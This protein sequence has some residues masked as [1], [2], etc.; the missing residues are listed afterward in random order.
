MSVTWKALASGSNLT[1]TPTVQ[2]TAPAGTAA[3]IQAVSIFNPT[4]GPVVFSMYRVPLN[5]VVADQYKICQRTIA[6]G[7]LVQGHEAINHKFESGGI[8]MAMGAGLML[9]VSGVEYV[10][11]S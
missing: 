2:Y 6:P 11:D 1:A 4:A 10:P 8:L 9:N 7:A 5:G 3:T